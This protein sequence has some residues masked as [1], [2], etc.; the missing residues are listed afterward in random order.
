MNSTVREFISGD[1]FVALIC[2]ASIACA[3]WAW[4]VWRSPNA[5]HVDGAT[6]RVQFHAWP[7]LAMAASGA[8]VLA[9]VTVLTF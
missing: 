5:W 9:I 2:F 1:G 3:V 7:E 6:K 4:R 8:A